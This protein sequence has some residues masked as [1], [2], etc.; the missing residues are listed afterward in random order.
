MTEPADYVTR[1]YT[2]CAA[3]AADEVANLFQSE[4]NHSSVVELLP[5]AGGDPDKPP[6]FDRAAVSVYLDPSCVTE[7]LESGL[8][9]KLRLLSQLARIGTLQRQEIRRE[10]WEESWK[11][12]YR[13]IKIGDRMVV[14][15]SW[16]E[17]RSSAG[18]IVLSLDPG[19]AFGTGIHPSTQMCL[20]RLEAWVSPGVKALDVGAGSGILTLGALALGASRVVAVDVDPVAVKTTDANI[21]RAGL[22]GRV[23]S[24]LTDFKLVAWEGI[25]TD[26][27]PPYD[28]VTANL[29]AGLILENLDNLQESLMPG[30]VLIASGIV[31][32]REP[33]ISAA[34]SKAGIAVVERD[35]QGDWVCLVLKKPR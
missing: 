25:P 11:K 26:F 24:I 6:T 17:Y 10:D 22:E 4:T 12:H 5:D 35:E 3:E 16:H 7:S 34:I 33:E 19:M 21:E 20:S 18:E 28:L 31:V 15:P 23:E 29:T 30:G 13:P 9:L 32:Q 8:D 14:C 27:R 2:E 1:L